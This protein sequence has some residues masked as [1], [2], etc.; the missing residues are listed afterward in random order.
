MR[1]ADWASCRNRMRNA[2]SVASCGFSSLIATWRPRRASV[3]T[4]TSAM[5]PRPMSEPT[6]YRPARTRPS[7]LT[8]RGS[9]QVSSCSSGWSRTAGRRC[10]T[11]RLLG[12]GPG[13]HVDGGGGG[14]RR[15]E[16]TAEVLEGHVHRALA[17]RADRDVRALRHRAAGRRW[18]DRR[19][20]PGS[21][22]GSGRPGRS[23][24]ATRPGTTRRC[25]PRPGRRS[26]PS[27]VP[28]AP[29]EP[30]STVI[31][32]SLPMGTG[33]VGFTA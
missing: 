8:V 2:G 32:T 16:L 5:P 13:D 28:P 21:R 7:S 26:A 23:L 27:R 25:E 4:C 12:V 22:T 14:G 15:A 10:A 31:V 20:R 24:R 29:Q 33:P 3:P 19:R 9:L 17:G 6:R 30:R 11:V 1:A 18:P